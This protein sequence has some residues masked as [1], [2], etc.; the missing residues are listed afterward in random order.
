MVKHIFHNIH[1]FILHFFDI[2]SEYALVAT[3]VKRVANC[4]GRIAVFLA[5]IVENAAER[6]VLVDDVGFIGVE[7]DDVDSC[8]DIA[9]TVREKFLA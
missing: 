5:H 2:F 1:D 7:L 6:D 8:I 3:D 9:A 4:L